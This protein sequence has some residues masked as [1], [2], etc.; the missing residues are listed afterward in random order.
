ML[1]AIIVYYSSIGTSF[2]V[3]NG[4]NSERSWH[5]TLF[6]GYMKLQVTL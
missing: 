4:S 1:E 2:L 5:L 6:V 3:Y